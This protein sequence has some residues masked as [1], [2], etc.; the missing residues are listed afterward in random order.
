MFNMPES[1]NPDTNLRRDEDTENILKV[2][3]A[4]GLSEIKIEKCFRLGKIQDQE[5]DRPLKVLLENKSDQKKILSAAKNLKQ[6]E[7]L[8]TVGIAPDLTF[9]QRNER[10]LMRQ[11][12]HQAEGDLFRDSQ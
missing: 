11:A 7:E 2:T 3:T 9:A 12:K 1:K 10:K 5:K 4:I 6:N 8:K